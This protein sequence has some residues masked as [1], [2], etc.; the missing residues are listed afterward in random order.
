[1]RNTGLMA[2]A[3]LLALPA[4]QQQSD[5]SAQRIALDQAGAEQPL[6]SPDTARAV[7][8]VSTDGKAVHFGNPGAQPWLTLACRLEDRANPQ[9]ALIRHAPAYPGQTALFA[10]VSNGYV[11]RLP[12]SATLAEG[13]W[14]WEAVL[15]AADPQWNPFTGTGEV[16][17]TL[18]GKGEIDMPQNPIPGEFVTWCRAG[19]RSSSA[20]TPPPAN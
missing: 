16:R 19:G 14:R 13:E 7:W 15:P 18:P 20:A 5:T 11:S 17:A 12:A 6:A 3:V 10:V 9:L 2:G 1:M 8:T 4:C